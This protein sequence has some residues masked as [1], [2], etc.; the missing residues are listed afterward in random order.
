MPALCVSKAWRPGEDSNLRMAER[1][2][3]NRR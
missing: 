2:L 3:P 1:L